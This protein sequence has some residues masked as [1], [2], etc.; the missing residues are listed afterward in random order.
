MEI[1]VNN[2]EMFLLKENGFARHF[3]NKWKVVISRISLSTAPE[4]VGKFYP[5]WNLLIKVTYKN[6]K[7]NHLFN[8]P[9]WHKLGGNETLCEGER[10]AALG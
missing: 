2:V 10:P 8:R 9:L 6:I 3:L 5:L 1:N 4:G 7:K